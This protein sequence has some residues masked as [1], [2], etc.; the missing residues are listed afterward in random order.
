M[1]KLQEEI[2]RV[3]NEFRRICDKHQLQYFAI[4]GTCIGAVRHSGFIPWDDDLDVGMPIRHYKRF[5]E[6][7]KSELSD[8]FE[9]MTPD[10]CKHY[11][12]IFIKLH[13]G[14]TTCIEELSQPYKDRYGGVY[15][16]I[17]P[18]YGLPNGNKARLKI[19]KKCQRL[20]QLNLRIRFPISDPIN[21]GLAR[22]LIWILCFPLRILHKFDHYTKKIDKMLSVYEFDNSDMVYFP[23][24][25]IPSPDT[26]YKDIFY[27]SDLIDTVELPFEDTVMKVPRGYDRYLRMDFGDYMQL[28]PEE[29]RVAGH[30]AHIIEFDTPYNNYK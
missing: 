10:N 21:K 6:L 1:T 2:L 4:G 15:I 25:T 13:D 16:D 17:F 24:R 28:P 8:G 19:E 26:T 22:K 27:L 30:S 7:A 11:L 12:S 3:F 29:M 14:K 20:K 9:V 5:I 18:I 23:W